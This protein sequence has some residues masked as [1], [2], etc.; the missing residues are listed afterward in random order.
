M[1]LNPKSLVFLSVVLMA[2]V[3]GADRRLPDRRARPV[4]PSP[5]PRESLVV[6]SAEGESAREGRRAG[7]APCRKPARLE[8]GKCVTDVVR[9]VTV[10]GRRA[11]WP[12]PRH[13]RR[14]LRPH[15]RP[16]PFPR[17]VATTTATTTV[18]TTTVTTTMDTTAGM[19][20][21]ATTTAGMTTTIDDDDDHHGGDDDSGHHGGRR[22]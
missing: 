1:S 10:P 12:L 17:P 22:R 16:H 3:L 4:A 11:R 21:T 2:G 8:G 9:T 20:R 19:A 14:H 5:A 6:D 7:F 15:L 13:R 18:G